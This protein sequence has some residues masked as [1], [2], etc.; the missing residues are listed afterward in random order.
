MLVATGPLTNVALA[1]AR[2]PELPRRLKRF[3]KATI[4]GNYVALTDEAPREAKPLS[5]GAQML[6]GA[7][8]LQLEGIVSK[9]R[10]A[11]YR[12]GRNGD[13]IMPASIAP[14]CSP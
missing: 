11:P 2:D 7:C 8:E 5:E 6:K 4:E 3:L 1:L 14:C 12:S 10:D 13:W 9:L